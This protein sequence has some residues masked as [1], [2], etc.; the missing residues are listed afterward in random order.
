LLDL[1]VERR[2]CGNAAHERTF[3]RVASRSPS[4]VR[5]ATAIAPLRRFIT[6]P[7]CIK[8]PAWPRRIRHRWASCPINRHSRE[9]PTA[10]GHSAVSSIEAYSTP[11]N[12]RRDTVTFLW[13]M[14]G[15]E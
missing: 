3:A 7:A 14:A 9:A 13:P 15:I 5:F 1:P 2:L 12:T 4:H 10:S 8:H 11:A 6:A